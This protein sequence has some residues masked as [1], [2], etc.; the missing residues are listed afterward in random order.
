LY[1]ID[2]E[3]V[4]DP[5]KLGEALDKNDISIIWL[6]SALF[7]QIAEI[8]TDIFSKLKYLLAGGDVLSV[9]HINKVRKDN[10]GLTV[11]NGYGPTE[12]TTFSTTYKVQKEFESSIPIG[13]PI[14]NSTA[15][16][17]DKYLNIQPVGI[18]GE[19]YVGGDGLSKGYLNRDDLNVKS[20][21]DNPHNPGERL[22]KTGDYVKWLPDGNLEFHGRMD[23]QLKIRGF[24][25][26]L[27]ELESVISEIEGVVETVV[28][29]LKNEFGD[30]RLAAFLNISETF[31]MDKNEL[32]RQ[33]K[34]KL[35]PYM[36][37]SAFKFMNG[38]PKNVNGK[39][40]KSKLVIDLNELEE[41]K[42]FD[43][44][45]FTPTELKIYEIWS[46]S[47]KLKDI[48]PSD[49]FFDI[50]GSSLTAI[51]VFSKIESAFNVELGLRVFFDA[52]RISDLAEA[53]DIYFHKNSNTKSSVED[54]DMDSGFVSGEI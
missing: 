4:L 16:V 33:L 42:T 45:K 25:V 31:T 50:G 2:K 1:V 19:L 37:P 52:P 32:S 43:I 41:A 6:T 12:N 21:I 49:N 10:P 9:T 24:R 20:F 18:V 48:N 51:S 14:S 7:T 30:I 38:F 15:Y 22:Y 17:F 54:M 8:R 34:E 44:D 13:K 53:I 36:I 35:P 39:T 27:G 3:T 46:E 28:K 47:L 26:E 29:P 40:D 11:I 23:N 5:K